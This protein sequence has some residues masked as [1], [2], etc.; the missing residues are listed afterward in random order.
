[1]LKAGKNGTLNGGSGEDSDSS[2]PW[3][4]ELL[5]KAYDESVRLAKED[6]AKKMASATNTTKDE[7]PKVDDSAGKRSLLWQPVKHKV[8]DFVRAV[9]REDGLEYE[10]VVVSSSGGTGKFLIKFIGYEN[11]QFVAA[12]ELKE[13]LGG[14][15]RMEQIEASLA[16]PTVQEDE[17]DSSVVSEEPEAQSSSSTRQTDAPPVAAQLSSLL[18][19]GSFVPPMTLQPPP[20]PPFAN[21][22]SAEGKHLAAMLMAWYTSGYYTGLY[23][24]HRMAEKRKETKKSKS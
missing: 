21:D 20:L 2:D 22:S 6:V 24:A 14:D 12:S 8:G 15:A 23:D 7:A 17:E 19:G 18:N 1:M 5:I 3:D 13:S 4:D 11:E 16:S 10:A 9:Y